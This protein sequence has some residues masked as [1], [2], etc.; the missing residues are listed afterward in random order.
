MSFKCV[1]R[2]LTVEMI[3]GTFVAVVLS[4]LVVF[5]IILSNGQWGGGS[6]TTFPLTFPMW[7]G[8]ALTTM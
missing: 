2:E 7:P 3:V 6:S 4:L 5:T 8:C 1:S